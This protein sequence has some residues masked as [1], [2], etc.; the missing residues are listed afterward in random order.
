MEINP[1]ELKIYMDTIFDEDKYN[2]TKGLFNWKLITKEQT[3]IIEY[4]YAEDL[5]N[6]FANCENS[7]TNKKKFVEYLKFK[8]EEADEEYINYINQNYN[9]IYWPYS[10]AGLASYTL[11][12]LGLTS[13]FIDSLNKRRKNSSLIFCL[14]KDL[15]NEKQINFNI[16]ELYYLLNILLKLDTHYNHES[17]KKKVLKTMTWNIFR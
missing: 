1:E 3:Q 12:K 7:K 10:E 11:I 4:K 6:L 5:L 8:L 15:L 17:V 14:F 2:S 16:Q 13:E 9:T